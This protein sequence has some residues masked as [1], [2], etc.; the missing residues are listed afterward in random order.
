MTRGEDG[1]NPAG[2]NGNNSTQIGRA[3]TEY[4]LTAKVIR[5]K[6]KIKGERY[7]KARTKET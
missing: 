6:P 2:G 1:G 7:G 4:F 3:K 5:E